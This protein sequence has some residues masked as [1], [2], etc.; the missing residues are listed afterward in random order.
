VR[1]RPWEAVDLWRCRACGTEFLNPQPTDERL[2]AIYG[3]DYYEP[4][5]HESADVVREMKQLT[6][7]P[8]LDACGL[9]AG[10]RVLDAG[11]ANGDL[12]AMAAER[13]LRAFGLDLNAAAIDRARSSV[14]DA[15]FAVGT[16][17]DRPFPDEAFEAVVMVDF[18]EHVRRP[19]HELEEVA[20]RLTPGGRLVL[21]T[22]RVDS[23]LRRLSG[24]VW[25]QYREEHLTYLSLVGVHALLQRTG[26]T[27]DREWS[28]R[29]ALTP[30]YLYGQALAYPVP[31]LTPLLRR[32][33]P[34]VPIP[35]HRPLRLQMG[36][37]T[38]VARVRTGLD[39]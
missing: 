8:I 17:G 6:M 4:W 39:A 33:W 32:V 34:V 12:V 15:Q 5:G 7:A 1:A 36:E 3:N 37:M 19:E 16:L 13:G 22:P 20:Q 29:K 10:E 35:K 26:F 25:P 9:V 24:A 30:A 38:V 23:R 27:V 31:V 2:D 28:T 11:C 14:P 21:S 18:I